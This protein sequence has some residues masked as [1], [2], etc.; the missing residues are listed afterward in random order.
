MANNNRSKFN[1]AFGVEAPP[2][3]EHLTALW[4]YRGQGG[5]WVMRRALA[6]LGLTL[7]VVGPGVA[8]AAELKPHM[9]G[10]ERIFTSTWQAGQYRGQPALEGYLTNVS[11][12]ELTYIR[13]LIESLDAGGQVTTQHIAWVP[14]ELGGGGR[15]FFQVPTAPAPAYRVRVYSYDRLERDGNFR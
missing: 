5:T 13:L 10:W 12:Y 2:V 14:G 8:G 1:V 7:L 15:L 6:I 11:P 9:A 3:G 4:Q